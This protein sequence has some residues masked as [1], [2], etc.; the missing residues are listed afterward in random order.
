[1]LLR[2]LFNKSNEI[3]FFRFSNLLSFVSLGAIAISI[4]L[5]LILGLNYGIDFRGGT[6]F[7]VSNS[8]KIE[9]IFKKHFPSG[10][11][12]LIDCSVAANETFFSS[13][14]LIINCISRTDLLQRSILVTQNTGRMDSAAASADNQGRHRPSFRHHIQILDCVHQGSRWRAAPRH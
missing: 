9:S 7:M 1:M 5:F 6:M 10:V 13:S 12:V 11:D 8:E 4:I 3:E 2:G 14:S